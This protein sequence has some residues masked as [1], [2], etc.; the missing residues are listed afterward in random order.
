MDP[1]GGRPLVYR[2]DPTGGYLLYSVGPDL[3][4]DLSSNNTLRRVPRGLEKPAG[5]GDYALEPRQR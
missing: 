2:L 1:Y 3:K 5:R 4:D